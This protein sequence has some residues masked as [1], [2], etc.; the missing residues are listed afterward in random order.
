M[1][2]GEIVNYKEERK[3][4]VI[5]N[6]SAERGEGKDIKIDN[7]LIN[8]DYYINCTNKVKKL[9]GIIISPFYLDYH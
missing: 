6:R 3:D 1:G 9:K 4:I 5:Y 7:N 8:H 2:G